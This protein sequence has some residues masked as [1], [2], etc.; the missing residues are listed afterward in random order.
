MAGG[1]A[2]SI[3]RDMWQRWDGVVGCEGMWQGVRACGRS[4]GRVWGHVA[5]V[6][7]FGRCDF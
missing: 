3:D 2:Y 4:G 5:G 7:V 6:G 1:Q